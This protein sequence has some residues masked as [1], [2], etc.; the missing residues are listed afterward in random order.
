MKNTLLISLVLLV[1]SG[2]EPNP[3]PVKT[4]HLHAQADKGIMV[5]LINY[6]I[7]I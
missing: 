6:S 4:R 1:I 2:I 7:A 3:G 5:V